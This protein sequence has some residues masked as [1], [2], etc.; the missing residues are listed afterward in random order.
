MK[1]I[2]IG[3]FLFSAFST[4]FA[5]DVPERSL[6][7]DTLRIRCEQGIGRTEEYYEAGQTPDQVGFLSLSQ[8]SLETCR[9]FAMK[10][11]GWDGINTFIVT[12]KKLCKQSSLQRSQLHEGACLLKLQQSVRAIVL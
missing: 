3:L 7:T 10:S 2:I 11:G 4:A 6:P 1:N 12:G 8:A 9:L 5:Q